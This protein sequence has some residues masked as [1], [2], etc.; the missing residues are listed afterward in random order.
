MKVRCGFVSNSSSTS[1]IIMRKGEKEEM[2]EAELRWLQKDMEGV[3]DIVMK[4][5]R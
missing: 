4:S 3:D 5:L 2:L 1:H